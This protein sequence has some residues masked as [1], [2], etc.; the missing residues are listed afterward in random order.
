MTEKIMLLDGFSLA[1]RAFFALPPLATSAGQP[2][3]AVYGLTMMLLKL[4][5]ESKPDYILMAFD[6]AAPTF[7]HQAY[8]AYKGQRLKMEDNLKVQFPIIRQLLAILKIPIIEEPG[9]E[10]DDLIGAMAKKAA[11]QGITVEIITG[12]RDAFQLVEPQIKVLFTRKGITEVDRVDEEFIFNRY[13]LKPEQLIDLKSLMG[14]TS[15][16]IPGVPGFGEKTALKYLH[17]YQTL[18]GIYQH[19][20]E[21]GKERDRELLNQYREQAY[22]S[23]HLAEIVTDITVAVDPVTCCQHKDYSKQELIG[24]CKEYEFHSLARKLSGGEEMLEEKQLLQL[25]FQFK[26]IAT[27]DL[28]KVADIIR[29]EQLCYIQ[30]FTTVTNWAQV[31]LLGLAIGNSN[32]NWFFPIAPGSELPNQLRSILE[33]QIITKYGHDLKKQLQI[34]VSQGITI[35]GQL[36]DLL[37]AGYLVNA[38]LG[39]LNLEDLSAAYLQKMLQA[40]KN[41]R[42]KVFSVFNLPEG[43]PAEELAKIAGARLEAMRLLWPRLKELLTASGLE[44]LYQEVEAPLIQV[45]FKMEKE[46]IKVNPET[47]REFGR[48]LKQRQTQ[49]ETEIYSLV[50]EEFNI[51]S[52]KQLGV[53]LFEKLG[54]K[55]PKKTKTGYSTDAEVLENLYDLHPVIPK[56]LEYRQNTKLQSTYI[57]SLIALINVQS[58]RV[59]TTFNQAVT[60]TGR[61]SCTEPNLQNIP[62]RSEEGRLIR[63]AFLPRDKQHRLLAADYSQIELRVMAHFSQDQAYK[64]AFLKGEDIHKFTAAAVCGVPVAQVTKEM[65]NQAKA[66]NFGIIYGISGFGLARNIGVSRKEADAFI[67]A[68]FEKYPGVKEYVEQL[69]AEAQ[70]TGEARTLMG[71]IRK[72]PDLHSRNFTLRSFAER[73]ARN[74][75]IQGTA[76]DIIKK[77]MVTIEKQLTAKPDLGKLLLQVHDELIFEVAESKWQELAKIV[78]KEMEGA[79]TLTVPLVVDLKL[80]INWGEMA[81]VILEGQ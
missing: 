42:G 40:W 61:L 55:A 46:G 21:I 50:N 13:Q 65:R 30:F 69:I 17:Q 9:Y 81:P 66:V 56:L 12:D 22:L 26:I 4:L 43:I 2:T 32:E 34:A 51:S 11:R 67:A 18:D 20:D 24:F 47:L 70:Q 44:I 45:L 19:I 10:A 25:D 36:E 23:R 74:T 37:I 28:D 38:G 33:D 59:H 48:I 8:Q 63:R 72:L 58:G 79:V 75:P 57:D 62:I 41:E 3:N 78:K 35:N 6:V 15:D 39:G 68:Y 76:A 14:D 80:G 5:E 77:A 29:Q 31:G 73:M 16:N 49:L 27:E 71:R 7:R 54:L 53:I 52:P 60:T 64:E 1:N